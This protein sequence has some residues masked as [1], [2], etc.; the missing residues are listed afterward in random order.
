M[1]R[2]R[3]KA[4]KVVLVESDVILACKD[5]LARRGYWCVRQ[6]VGKLKTPDGRWITAGY[7]GLPDYATVHA[8]YPGFLIEFK[9]PGAVPKPHQARTIWELQQ[10]FGL[11]IYVCDCFE[12]LPAIVNAHE[13]RFRYLVPREKARS[14]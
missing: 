12:V 2:F 1:N 7:R 3:L 4:N 14:P 13:D 8:F 9:R 6:H 5:Y 11:S 10:G